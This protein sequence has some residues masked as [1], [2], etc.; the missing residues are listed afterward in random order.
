MIR[1]FHHHSSTTSRLFFRSARYHYSTEKPSFDGT[2]PAFSKIACIGTGKMAHALLKPMITTGFHPAKD[3]TVFD[4]STN[5]MEQVSK[6]L[7]VKTAES[8][9]EAIEDA[10]FILCAVKPQNLNSAFFA[11]FRKAQPHPNA[12]L[13][14]VIAGKTIDVFHHTHINKIVRS[15]PNTPAQVGEGMTVWSCTPNL[16]GSDRNLIQTVLSTCGHSMYVDDESYIDMAT[17]ISG[18]G[19]AYIFLLMESMIDGAVHMGFP[20]DKATTL[21][22]HTMLGSTLYAME[23][24][25]HPAI[26]R[27][28]VTSPSGTTASALYELENGK[29]RTVI[30]DAMWACYRR[31][32]EMG[33]HDSNVGP[34]RSQSPHVV[35]AA[36]PDSELSNSSDDEDVRQR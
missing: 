36:T 16:T 31:S 3:F 28:M 8:I 7:G 27:N 33:N 22:Y 5:L 11:E 20:R 4:V 34:G 18:S 35:H 32:L 2:T 25:E 19:P 1:L 13:L 14:S 15:M 24:G 23:S 6:E 30:K 26:L 10:D 21:V 17:S 9:P 29:I 12:I